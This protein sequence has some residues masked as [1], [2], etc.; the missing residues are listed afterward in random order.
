M[1][2]GLWFAASRFGGWLKAIGVSEYTAL[3]DPQS[4]LG[5]GLVLNAGMAQALPCSGRACSKPS[6]ATWVPDAEQFH[7]RNAGRKW[8]VGVTF[9]YHVPFGH[10]GLWLASRRKVRL[11]ASLQVH[12]YSRF[13]SFVNGPCCEFAGHI[14]VPYP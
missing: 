6:R 14:G 1:L 8:V 12:S 13:V 5:A 3:F 9:Y 11:A 10:G 4:N 7:Y 2:Y